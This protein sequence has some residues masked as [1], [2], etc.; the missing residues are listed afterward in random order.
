MIRIQV[1]SAN[2]TPTAAAAAVKD[3]I[4]ADI[5]AGRLA[6]T[7][8][9]LC[10]LLQGWGHNQI[11]TTIPANSP[12]RFF[13]EEDRLPGIVD[14]DVL[15]FTSNT[16][17]NNPS[18]TYRH[19]WLINATASDAPLK[20]WTEQFVAAYIALQVTYPALPTPS[21]MYFDSEEYIAYPR[22]RQGVWLLNHVAG[23]SLWNQPVPGWG[24]QTAAQLYAAAATAY[25]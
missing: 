4:L 2:T 3:R 19:P 23:T 6:P 7:G 24:G 10:F 18:R 20:L 5:A 17:P 16:D 8:A 25:G 15:P 1:H 11:T 13:R 21:R 9:N 12:V 14:D 22:N